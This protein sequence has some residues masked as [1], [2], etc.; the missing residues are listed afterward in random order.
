MKKLLK[1]A[2][3]LLSVIAIVIGIYIY[4]KNESIPRGKEGKKADELAL[5]MLRSLN[6]EAYKTTRFIE[7]SF[8]GKHFYKWD[9]ELDTVSVQ[10]GDN[11]VS[12]NTKLS[13]KSIV[14]IKNK[15][16]NY[17]FYFKI[18]I[19]KVENLDIE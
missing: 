2:G 11:R 15:K 5:K 9:K 12:L 13:E 3:F 17:K 14:Y 19:Y 8:R 10:W 6:Y 18:I 4:S 1:I 16:V 7:W